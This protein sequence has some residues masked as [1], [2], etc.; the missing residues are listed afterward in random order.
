MKLDDKNSHQLIQFIQLIVSMIYE[1]EVVEVFEK[2]FGQSI[3]AN[4]QSIHLDYLF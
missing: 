4:G 1:P 2:M 3:T